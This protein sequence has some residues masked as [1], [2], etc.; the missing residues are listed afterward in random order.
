MNICSIMLC[1]VSEG[2]VH[3]FT[4][5]HCCVKQCRINVRHLEDLETFGSTVSLVLSPWQSSGYLYN[6]PS[7]SFL[8]GMWAKSRPLSYK[9]RNP[10][11]APFPEVPGLFVSPTKF[12][13]YVIPGKFHGLVSAG[14]AVCLILGMSEWLMLWCDIVSVGQRRH[15]TAKSEITQHYTSFAHHEQT[16]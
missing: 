8:L 6:G 1:C 3:W 4:C 7:L 16:C 10:L 5:L 14:D 15:G 2:P 11:L 9:P 12:L 13:P